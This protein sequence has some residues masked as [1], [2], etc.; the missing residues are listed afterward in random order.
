MGFFNIFKSEETK[1]P[2]NINRNITIVLDN[3]HGRET[4]GKR[5]PKFEDGTQFFEWEFNRDIVNRIAAQLKDLNIPYEILV[6][7]TTDISL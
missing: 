2:D 7:E 6:P 4:P 3:G 1:Q 5:S